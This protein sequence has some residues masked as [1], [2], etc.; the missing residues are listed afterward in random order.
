M[1]EQAG[2]PVRPVNSR[3]LKIHTYK[4]KGQ[5]TAQLKEEKNDD[6]S[7]QN[8]TRT[9]SKKNYLYARISFS[10]SCFRKCLT[11]LESLIDLE[12][13]FQRTGPRV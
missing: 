8:K 4:E 3:P 6:D 5:F 12:S 10:L 1:E 9:T 2:K 11:D 13:E 7:I